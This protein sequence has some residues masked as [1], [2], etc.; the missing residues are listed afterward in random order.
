MLHA[1]CDYWLTYIHLMYSNL[2]RSL[3]YV[4]FKPLHW[5]YRFCTCVDWLCC[6]FIHSE[7][8]YFVMR[9]AIQRTKSMRLPI[10]LTKTVHATTN[11]QFFYFFTADWSAWRSIALLSTLPY[12]RLNVVPLNDATIKFPHIITN[13]AGECGYSRWILRTI[14][15]PVSS[16]R[17]EIVM[18]ARNRLV[19]ID[20]IGF[21]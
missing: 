9:T 18:S 8:N 14:V 7:H 19:Q 15:P 20:S 3:K 10:Y 13:F 17:I 2:N 1:I 5:F 6:G 11:R 4:S 12:A 16:S 21:P